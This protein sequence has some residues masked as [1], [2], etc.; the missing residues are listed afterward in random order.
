MVVE[1]TL[2]QKR[3]LTFSGF[4]SNEHQNAWSLRLDTYQEAECL[5]GNF[6]LSV[7]IWVEN[8]MIKFCCLISRTFWIW[9]KKNHYGVWLPLMANRVNQTEVFRNH[10]SFPSPPKPTPQVTLHFLDFEQSVVGWQGAAGFLVFICTWQFYL[11][12]KVG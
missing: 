5:S 6:E 11:S 10:L 4:E 3:Y 8:V 2:L 9:K 12:L 7:P 1:N